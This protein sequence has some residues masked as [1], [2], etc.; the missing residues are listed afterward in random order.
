MTSKEKGVTSGKEKAKKNK[1]RRKAG[2]N[3][4]TH[5]TGIKRRKRDLKS[6][7]WATEE[8]DKKR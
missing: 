3:I 4:N 2:G 8:K 6:Q 5:V 7:C 1:K